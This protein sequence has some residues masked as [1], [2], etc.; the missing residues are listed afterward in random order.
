MEE[1][2]ESKLSNHIEEFG[3]MIRIGLK[4]IPHPKSYNVSWVNNTSIAIKD[5]CFFPR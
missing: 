2:G 1:F 5:R 4:F 3:N